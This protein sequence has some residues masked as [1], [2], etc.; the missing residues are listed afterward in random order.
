MQQTL[1]T[2][3][4][5]LSLSATGIYLQLKLIFIPCS[6]RNENYKDL[7]EEL[8][9]RC[10]AFSIIGEN[11]P[12]FCDSRRSIATS[13]ACLIF[14]LLL[15]SSLPSVSFSLCKSSFLPSSCFTFPHI[16]PTIFSSLFLTVSFFPFTSLFH[17]LTLFSTL[18]PDIL[19]HFLFFPLF[20]LL[21][22][23]TLNPS[24]LSFSFVLFFPSLP[25]PL[26]FSLSIS[27][28]FLFSQSLLLSIS[29]PLPAYLFPSHF[30]SHSLLLPYFLSP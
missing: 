19:T 23:P 20:H 4:T 22:I 10:R 1:T 9:I 13:I 27:H 21:L 29:L 7:R 30:L 2:V 15:F 18:L 26:L 24:S 25:H 16:L 11:K 6:S 5:H 8:L 28:I 12:C 3:D 14:F 17:Y